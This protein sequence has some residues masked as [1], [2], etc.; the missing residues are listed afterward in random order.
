MCFCIVIASSFV[1]LDDVCGCSFFFTF[2]AADVDNSGICGA[3]EVADPLDSCSPLRNGFG[4]NVSEG[5]V[6]VLIVRGN[7]SFEEK[8][9]NAQ[10]HGF[11]A[12]IVYD[13]RKGDL[14]YSE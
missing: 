4:R 8:I 13:D 7:C 14:V 11:G 2:E 5:L 10:S 1:A 3:L 6:F 9:V 12:V